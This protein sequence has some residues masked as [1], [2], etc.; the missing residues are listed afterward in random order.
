MLQSE[1]WMTFSLGMSFSTWHKHR[2]PLRMFIIWIML[3]THLFKGCVKP[4]EEEDMNDVNGKRLITSVTH[5][6][7]KVLSVI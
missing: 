6:G 1:S 3:S 4:F 5:T 7:A 2:I